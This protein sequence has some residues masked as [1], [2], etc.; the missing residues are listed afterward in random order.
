MLKTQTTL[1]S[2]STSWTKTNSKY[3]TRETLSRSQVLEEDWILRTTICQTSLVDR[4][5]KAASPTWTIT[6]LHRRPRSTSQ[7]LFS[8]IIC[9]VLKSLM[10]LGHLNSRTQRALLPNWTRRKSCL[11]P[12]KLWLSRTTKVSTRVPLSITKMHLSWAMEATF[13]W[14]QTRQT[15]TLAQDHIRILSMAISTTW[16][17]P[18]IHRVDNSTPITILVAKVE[19]WIAKQTKPS[20]QWWARMTL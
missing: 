19:P 2:S 7:T 12:A 18:I 13:R 8:S 20:N 4:T 16:R 5:P 11:P 15:W 17:A 1:N 3:K 10:A 6:D 9:K 14:L